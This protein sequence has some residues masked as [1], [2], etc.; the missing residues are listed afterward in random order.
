MCKDVRTSYWLV[1]WNSNNHSRS[2]RA[3]WIMSW[4]VAG[5]PSLWTWSSLICERDLPWEWSGDNPLRP[6]SAE[7]GDHHRCMPPRDP[8]SLTHIRILSLESC[9]WAFFVMIFILWTAWFLLFQLAYHFLSMLFS[10]CV[11]FAMI[12]YL[13][14][15]QRRI[16]MKTPLS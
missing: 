16:Q 2:D 15:E 5:G 11:S 7:F 4:G 8:T 13:W 1:Y 9:N 3:E 10:L 14:C 12:T 6:N